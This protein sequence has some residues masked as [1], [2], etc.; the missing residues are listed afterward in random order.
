MRDSDS[1]HFG[2]RSC[3]ACRLRNADR[4]NPQ[5]SFS[6]TKNGER[7]RSSGEQSAESISS[8]ESVSSPSLAQTRGSSQSPPGGPQD[9]WSG[10]AAP[11]IPR[12]RRC[13]PSALRSAL[14]EARAGP[15]A[16]LRRLRERNRLERRFRRLRAA[17]FFVQPHLLVLQGNYKHKLRCPA[18]EELRSSSDQAVQELHAVGACAKSAALPV[19]RPEP[20]RIHWSRKE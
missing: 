18:G 8:G 1:H 6:P 10:S 5:P 2:I 12:P 16:R 11:L 20:A 3:C 17:E 15:R 4:G 14:R 7:S 13:R 19:E 9:S